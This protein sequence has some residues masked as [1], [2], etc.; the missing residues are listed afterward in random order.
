MTCLRGCGCPSFTAAHLRMAL[1]T[2]TQLLCTWLLAGD[3]GCRGVL[4]LLGWE[5]VAQI[6]SS[7]LVASSV[8][9]L[10]TFLPAPPSQFPPQPP[11]GAVN[12]QVRSEPSRA[13]LLDL[14]H[15]SCHLRA[16]TS[17]SVPGSSWTHQAHSYPWAFA[18]VPWTWHAFPG[19]P[20][21]LLTVTSGLKSMSPIQGDLC[22]NSLLSQWTLTYPVVSTPLA[23]TTLKICNYCSLLPGTVARSPVGRPHTVSVQ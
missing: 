5:R 20:H 3:W 4:D 1:K 23:F 18:F 8:P 19:Y 10:G 11:E 9:R 12:L 21:T 7:A 6:H 22:F 17:P 14:C 2:S 13:S 16:L 15:P